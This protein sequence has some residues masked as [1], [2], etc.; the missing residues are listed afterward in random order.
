MPGDRDRM[1]ERHHTPPFEQSHR[2]TYT[3]LGNLCPKHH[4]LVTHKHYTTTDNHD[5]TWDLHA[6]AHTQPDALANAP[7]G[8]AAA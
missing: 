7:P 5:G 4:D 6:P 2:T 3:E 8:K 1:L